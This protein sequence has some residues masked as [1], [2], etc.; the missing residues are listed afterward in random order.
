[1]F[2][3][4]YPSPEDI[5]LVQKGQGAAPVGPFIAVGDVPLPPARLGGS[6]SEIVESAQP[7]ASGASGASSASAPSAVRRLA[8]MS[9]PA[10]EPP[11]ARALQRWWVPRR[12]PAASAPAAA[13]ASTPPSAPGA[14]KKGPRG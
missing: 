4:R 2:A 14:P 13:A 1:M 3:G 5:A 11:Q 8:P 6:E 9:A 12:E 7:A 10:D